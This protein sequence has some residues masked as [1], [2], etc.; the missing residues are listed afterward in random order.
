MTPHAILAVLIL[1]A[2]GYV[3]FG[4][5]LAVPGLEENPIGVRGLAA[6]IANTH[7]DGR[8]DPSMLTAIAFVE[9]SF[10]PTATRVEVAIGDVSIGLMQTLLSTARWLAEDMG[11]TA[12]GVPGPEDLLDPD[13]SMYFGAA[14]VDYLSHR[15]P[16]TR[17][18]GEERIVR[19]YNGGPGGAS[20]SATAPY[21]TKYQAARAL[22]G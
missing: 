5:K 10:N 12:F 7:F 20:S 16:I 18:Q 4:G 15:N 19:A 14:Y 3:L 21:W 17:G 22:Y 6:R 9:S 13:T 8:V 1:A 11:Y 2:L